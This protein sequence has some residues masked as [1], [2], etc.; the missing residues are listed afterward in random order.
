MARRPFTVGQET[1][2][3]WPILD[4]ANEGLPPIAH[5]VEKREADA[6]CTHEHVEANY[7]SLAACACAYLEGPYTQVAFEQLMGMCYLWLPD[8]YAEEFK[9]KARDI[10]NKRV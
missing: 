5:F 9:N 3:G 6:F 8:D 4:A 2:K 7:D 10:F 1:D